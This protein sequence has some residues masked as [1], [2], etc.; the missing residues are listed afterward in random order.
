MVAGYIFCKRKVGEG[1]GVDSSPRAARMK[2]RLHKND[3]PTSVVEV[4]VI[5]LTNLL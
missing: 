3:R 2:A 1:T 5:F 4:R